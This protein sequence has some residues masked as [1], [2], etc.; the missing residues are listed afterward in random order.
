MKTDIEYK[1]H[2]DKA[3]FLLLNGAE[4]VEIEGKSVINCTFVLKVS[5]DILKLHKKGLVKYSTY[6]NFRKKLKNKM[7][8]AFNY[9]K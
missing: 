4:L 3:A 8:K 9:Y 7:F 5:T 1:T 2:L 6:M